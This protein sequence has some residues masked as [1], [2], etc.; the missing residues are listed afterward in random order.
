MQGFTFKFRETTRLD[1]LE[2]LIIILVVGVG[3]WGSEISQLSLHQED[4]EMDSRHHLAKKAAEMPVV[5]NNL[6]SLDTRGE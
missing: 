2:A 4:D 6:A 3:A 5:G 1:R